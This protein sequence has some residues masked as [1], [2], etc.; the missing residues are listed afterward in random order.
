MYLQVEVDVD[1]DLGITLMNGTKKRV[2]EGD[3]IGRIMG[4]GAAAVCGLLAWLRWTQVDWTA[5]D[6]K[7]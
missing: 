7:R 3:L 6:E 2:E 4:G 1:V 5:L